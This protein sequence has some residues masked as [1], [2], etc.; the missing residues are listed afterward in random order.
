VFGEAYL[1]MQPDDR[2]AEIIE[3]LARVVRPGGR[4]GLHE[5]ALVPDNLDPATRN[6]VRGDLTGTIKVNVSPLTTAEWIEL[7]EG[8]GFEVRDRF[9]APLHLLEPR[10]LLADE[11]VRG[12]ARFVGNVLRQPAA[13]K[14]VL[15]MRSAM[16]RNA[17]HLQACVLV[18]TRRQD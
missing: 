3:E 4:L 16:G 18:A 12:T 10:R 2:K 14:R 17:C 11:G 1:T 15:A 7:L 8:A 5:V 13:R 9:T 6:A